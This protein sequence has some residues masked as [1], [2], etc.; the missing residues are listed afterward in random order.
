MKRIVLSLFVIAASAQS[1]VASAASESCKTIEQRI[2]K[3]ASAFT[4]ISAD[5][6]AKPS[7]SRAQPSELY[8]DTKAKNEQL[9]NTADQLWDLRSEMTNRHCT[10]ANRFSY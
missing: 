2:T 7:P 4:K 10:Q 9:Q 8:R 1:G 3:S 6:A 5:T